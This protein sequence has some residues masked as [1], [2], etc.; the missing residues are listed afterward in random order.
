MIF[1]HNLKIVS[2]LA[3]THVA[4][5][6]SGLE[7]LKSLEKA[8]NTGDLDATHEIFSAW[9]AQQKPDAATG[10]IPLPY[11]ATSAMS[12]AATNDHPMCLAYLLQQGVEIRIKNSG[13]DVLSS[14]VCGASRLKSTRSLQVL[15]D[16][17][18]DINMPQSDREPPYMR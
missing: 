11:F 2:N 17:G 15:L 14:A 3:F 7:L 12:A 18:W 9:F 6:A 10:L 4:P 5:M 16:N 13:P 1:L 8:C